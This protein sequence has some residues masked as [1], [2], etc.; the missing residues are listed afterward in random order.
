MFSD[1]IRVPRISWQPK[2]GTSLLQYLVFWKS[3]EDAGS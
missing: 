1:Q 3:C 2:E